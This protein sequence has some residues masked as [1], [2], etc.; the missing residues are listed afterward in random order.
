MR[1]MNLT[2]AVRASHNRDRMRVIKTSASRKIRPEDEMIILMQSARNRFKKS[3][4][5][6]QI[7]IVNKREWTLR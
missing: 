6:G 7:T 5:S 4:A 3:V 1:E 2:D